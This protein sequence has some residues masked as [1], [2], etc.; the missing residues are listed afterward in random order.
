MK[1][2]EAKQVCE[3]LYL[4]VDVQG[5]APSSDPNVV[6][7]GIGRK[8]TRGQPTEELALKF[9]VRQKLH[10]LLVQDG[11][12]IPS[13]VDDVHTV[14]PPCSRVIVAGGMTARS[15]DDPFQAARS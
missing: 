11:Q 9:Y 12:V 5:L 6:G 10:P 2:A 7:V 3:C 15:P 13:E 4:G 14:R 8:E 1:A